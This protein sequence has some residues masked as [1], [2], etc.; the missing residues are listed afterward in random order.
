MKPSTALALATGA[1]AAAVAARASR[2]GALKAHIPGDIPED[3]EDNT[4]GLP[5]GGPIRKVLRRYFREQLQQMVGFVAKLG[6]EIPRTFPSVA[7]YDD[8][9]ASA[10]TPLIGMYWDKSGKALRGRLGLDE[11]D[12]RVTDPN[13]HAAIKNQCLKFCKSTNATTDL[14]IAEARDAVRDQ[15]ARGLIGDGESIPQLTRRIQSVFTT[16]TKSRAQTIARTETARAVHTASEMSAEQSGVVAA[17]K[18]LVSAHSGGEDTRGSSRRGLRN[19]R[20]GCGLQHDPRPA[21]PSQLQ[22]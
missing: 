4:F 12:W 3:N 22:M 1:L 17:K 13:I 11:Q 19:D 16:A 8:P 15:L 14:G 6:V 2:A 18:W 5:D 10:M 21:G 20:K 7:N 9:M